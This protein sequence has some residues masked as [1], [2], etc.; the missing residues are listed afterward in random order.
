MNT[1]QAEK[2]MRFADLH[3]VAMI[4]YDGEAVTIGSYEI[5]TTLP[6]GDELRDRVAYDRCTS[7]QQLRDALGY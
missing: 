2:L 6:E 7:A 1:Q 3:D 5:D 4:C